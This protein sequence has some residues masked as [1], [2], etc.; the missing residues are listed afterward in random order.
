[1][2]DRPKRGAAAAP[3]LQSLQVQWSVNKNTAQEVS[4]HIVTTATL[5]KA[6]LAAPVIIQEVRDGLSV[7]AGTAGHAQQFRMT[8]FKVDQKESIPTSM[9]K[10][11][12]DDKPGYS[13]DHGF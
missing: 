5:T 12:Y 10:V 1:M 9:E 11:I 3:A 2:T 4:F 7:K 6:G 8:T 13:T